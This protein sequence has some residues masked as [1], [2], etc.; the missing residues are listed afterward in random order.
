MN[1][2]L[3]KTGSQKARNSAARLMAAQAVYQMH[4]NDQSA[5]DVIAEYLE[6][7]VGVD[8]DG[9]EMVTPDIDHFSTIINGVE[10][11]IQQLSE[12]VALNRQK[13]G[14]QGTEPLLQAIFLCG[15]YELMVLQSIDYPIIISE[16]V[17]VAQAFYEENEAKLVNA[18]LDSIRKTT[19]S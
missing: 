6:H 18:V 16:Y 13:Q 9:D 10:Q 19:R 17:H 2:P 15:A 5:K 12:I 14:E 7:R 11:H 8:I 4:K 1:K 3:K